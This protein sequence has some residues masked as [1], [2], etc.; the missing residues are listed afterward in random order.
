MAMAWKRRRSPA[1]PQYDPA[2]GD[3]ALSEACQDVAAGRWQ[4][5]R[6]LLAAGAPRDWDRRSHRIRLLADAAA[7]R[8]V[9]E[10]WQ[11]SE[12]DSPDALVLRADIE[13]MRMFAVARRGTMPAVNRL[14]WTARICLQAS[15]AAPEDPHPWVSLVTLARLYEGGHAAM[16]RWWQELCARDP[17]H[18]EAHHQGLRYMS[19]RWHGSHG[20][21]Y[22]FARDRA[23]A[24]PLGSPL[25]VLP[26]VARAEQYRHRAE[27]E[28]RNS[29][30]LLH[31]W[32]GDAGRWDL[33]TTMERWIGSRTAPQA[34]D[35]ADLN[36]LAHG[37]VHADMLAEAATVFDLLDGR[38]TRVPWAYTGDPEQQYVRWRARTRTAGR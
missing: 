21:A 12:P 28:G 24:A 5:L 15:E 38:A 37:L 32:S 30:D 11:A 31:H 1:A 27:S 3:K 33:R 23:A 10:A 2:F 29:L 36:H 14:D 22:N 20:Q 26:Q 13:V 25:A 19:A 7:D 16:G 34:Q 4:G 17:Y 8:R 9:A 18:R 35:V 6:D